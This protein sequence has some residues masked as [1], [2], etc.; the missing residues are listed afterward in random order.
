MS[1]LHDITAEVADI[2][3]A[4]D[5]GE[6][7]AEAEARLN[8]L[9]LALPEKVDAILRFVEQCQADATA[10]ETTAKRLADLARADRG[11]ADRLKRYVLD[12]LRR[13]DIQRIDTALFKVSVCKNGQ[14][15]VKVAE[16][17]DLAD[18]PAEYHRLRLELDR[19]KVLQDAKAG[20]P[21]PNGLSVETGFHLRTK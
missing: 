16:G 3:T 2:L 6:L 13:L 14:P 18:L 4:D 15:S 5:D 12:C 10:R 8:D 11:K 20:W 17:V 21:L 19:E 9:Q 7:S 1:T